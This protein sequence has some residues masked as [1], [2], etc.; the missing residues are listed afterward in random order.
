MKYR[1]QYL[2]PKK[3]GYA[4]QNAVFYEIEDA[5]LWENAIKKQGA[6]EI[7]IVPS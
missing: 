7:I 5:I 2:Q 3:R 1:V 6:K 4:K